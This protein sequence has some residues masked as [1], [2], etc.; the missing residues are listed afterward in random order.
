M[1]KCVFF[2]AVF[3][4][5]HT[6]PALAQSSFGDT[7][8]SFNA[9]QLTPSP[10]RALVGVEFAGGHFWVTGVNPPLYDHRL[11]K[12]SA[13]G[14]TLVSYTS[15]GSG[16]HAYFDLAYDGEFLYATDRD[17]IVQI[18]PDSGLLT[19]VEI[20]ISFGYLLVQGLAYDPASDHFWVIPQ[21]NAQLQIIHEIDRAGNILNTYPNLPTDYTTSLAWDQWSPNGPYLWTFSREEIGYNSRT[22]MRQFS[23]AIG[24]F[25]GIE[26]EAVNRS[27][28][29]LDGPLGIAMSAELDTSIISMIALQS[30]ALQVTDGL[31]WM[32]VYDADLR[33]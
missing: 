24:A 26:I 22:V 33:G 21:R 3:L 17:R 8:F 30:G 6:A 25:T 14:S 10:D 1:I 4:L 7:L 32:V 31:D 27:P 23:P 28:V 9:G 19:G 13:D 5:L 18:D 29:V 11:Y 2:I 16:Y 15:L 12:I 20:S